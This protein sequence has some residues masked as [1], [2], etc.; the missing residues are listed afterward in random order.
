MALTFGGYSAD[1]PR[2]NPGK[3]FGAKLLSQG[4]EK[5]K[6]FGRTTPAEPVIDLSQITQ[7]M[8]D[9]DAQQRSGFGVHANRNDP[10]TIFQT[11]ASQVKTADLSPV[12]LPP[13]I[14]GFTNTQNADGS[15]VLTAPVRGGVRRPKPAG[16]NSLNDVPVDGT[17]AVPSDKPEVAGY[18]EYADGTGRI[19]A[20]AAPAVAPATAAPT[21]GFQPAA[22]DMSPGSQGEW[23][24]NQSAANRIK[25]LAPDLKNMSVA[26]LIAYNKGLKALGVTSEAGLRTAQGKNLEAEMGIKQLKLPSEIGVNEAKAFQDVET[27]KA[28][29]IT[30]PATAAASRAS[31]V[32]SLADAE[33]NLGMMPFKQKEALARVGLYGAQAIHTNK[34]TETAPDKAEIQAEKDAAKLEQIKQ[35][36]MKAAADAAA[37]YRTDNP[38]DEA[39]AI[40]AGN[41]AAALIRGDVVL[42]GTP[43]VEAKKGFFGFGKKARVP[44]GPN[45]I[46]P[47]EQAGNIDPAVAQKLLVK[48]N[49]DPAKAREAY[50]K[51]E[52]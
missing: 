42:P 5:L 18:G 19:Y 20:Q 21:L 50:R 52:R 37:K 32:K 30:A 3:G 51:G 11:P 27:G 2:N 7:S 43:A 8:S 44:A 41:T 35:A 26:D 40:N 12:K 39:G 14:A 34:L 9:W 48:Y 13:K 1:D 16:S 46:I 25:A 4:W 29:G 45:I 47:K 6:S 15:G 38:G 17:V 49:N 10:A 23:E 28:I 24:A 33:E 22:V 31:A 36:Q